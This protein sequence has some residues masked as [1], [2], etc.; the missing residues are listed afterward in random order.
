MD[1]AG[2]GDVDDRPAAGIDH[3]LAHFR[4]KPE[5]TFQI[6]VQHLVV[7]RL[8]DIRRTAVE[9]RH[10]GVVD[11]HVDLAEMSVNRVDQ[12]VYLIPV[13]DVAAMG[14]SAP[15][16]RLDLLRHGL[17]RIG[18]AAGDRDIGAGRRETQRHFPSHT[19]AAA[20][21]QDDLAG[22]IDDVLGHRAFL[23]SHSR[24]LRP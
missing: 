11:Q 4:A 9:R 22:H 6:D 1:R 21:D 8:R 17:A 18:L 10:A 19:A 23:L 13:A 3:A 16:E 20:G 7:Q 2:A 24:H 15:A 5:R 12:P 14:E